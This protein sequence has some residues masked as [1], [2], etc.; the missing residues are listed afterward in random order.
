MA[1]DIRIESLG[2][3]EYLVRFPSGSETVESLMRATPD[4]VDHIGVPGTDER[5][6]VAETAAFLAERQPVIDIPPMIDLDDLEAHYGDEY[7]QELIRR[8]HTAP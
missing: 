2:D 7:L 3:H 5:R 8:L 4:T 6:I 1:A